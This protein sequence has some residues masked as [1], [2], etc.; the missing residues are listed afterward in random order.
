MWSI[1]PPD[2]TLWQFLNSQLLATIVGALVVIVGAIIGS[3]G[4]SRF[5]ELAETAVRILAEMGASKSEQEG[6]EVSKAKQDQVDAIVNQPV[7]EGS[8][9]WRGEARR[10]VE[11]GKE[12]LDKKAENDPD[13]RYRRTYE[14]ITRHDYI[15]LAVAMNDRKRLTQ[16]QFDAATTLFTLWKQYERGRASK[17]PVSQA[18]YNALNQA[19]TQLIGSAA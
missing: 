2:L 18:A 9:D 10:L 4:L 6:A 14:A 3:K 11:S 8:K 16:A 13:G 1:V 19:Y 7:D 12:F 5:A 17:R 15:A